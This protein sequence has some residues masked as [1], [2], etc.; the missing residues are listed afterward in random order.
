[1]DARRRGYARLN[2]NA[3]GIRQD[4]PRVPLPDT[5]E[6]LEHS[7]RLGRELAALLDPET[8]VPGVTAGAIRP[9]LKLLAVI[10]KAFAP[11]SDRRT[12]KL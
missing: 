1:V 4:W 7:A 9:E 10:S 8:P 11:L 3:D 12:V 2:E 5:R 6:A